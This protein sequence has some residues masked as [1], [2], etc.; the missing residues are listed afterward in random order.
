VRRKV[1][2]KSRLLRQIP[3]AEVNSDDLVY[4]GRCLAQVSSTSPPPGPPPQATIFDVAGRELQRAGVISLSTVGRPTAD[5]ADVDRTAVKTGFA[6]AQGTIRNSIQPRSFETEVGFIVYGTR[7]RN[8]ISVQGINTDI[9]SEGDGTLSSTRVRLWPDTNWR[10]GSVVLHF[11]DGSGTVIAALAGYIANVVVENGS[12]VNVSYVPS[13][14]NWRWF[15]YQQYREQLDQLHAVVASAARYG[16]F[17]IEG[18][19]EDKNRNAERLADKIRI[20]KGIDPTLGLYAAYAYADADLIDKARSV[21]D[22]MRGDLGTDIFDVA[23]LSGVLSE[24]RVGDHHP[25]PFCPML[26][27][28]WTLLRVKAVRLPPKV[29]AARDHL[30]PSLWTTFNPRGMELVMEAMNLERL[31]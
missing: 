27:Q 31:R 1:E 11:A 13:M 26:S 18:G 15:D 14:N 29:D 21:Y 25:V 16:V 23:M 20:L 30:R 12:V 9:W 22:F 19:K 28:G 8:A 24:N 3:D 2:A 17:R 10:A 4:I 5:L 6:S 7:L